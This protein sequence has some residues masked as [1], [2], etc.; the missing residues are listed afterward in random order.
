[1]ATKTTDLEVPGKA[2]E[3]QL[4]KG[5]DPS[6]ETQLLGTPAQGQRFSQ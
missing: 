1:M 4:P 5:A 6:K 3:A 2:E